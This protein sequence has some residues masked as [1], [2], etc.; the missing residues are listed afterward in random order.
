MDDLFLAETA[1]GTTQD[2]IK[3]QTSMLSAGLEIPDPSNELLKTD[4]LDREATRIVNK[5]NIRYDN[6]CIKYFNG[7]I[8]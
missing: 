3:T 2:K 8:W 7:M 6:E 4:A 5:I 1:N